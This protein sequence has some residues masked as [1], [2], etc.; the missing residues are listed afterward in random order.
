MLLPSCEAD[1]RQ[2]Q[3]Q[4]VS[5]FPSPSA[6]MLQEG[7]GQPPESL[8][9]SLPHFIDRACLVWDKPFLVS[10]LQF[11]YLENVVIMCESRFLVASDRNPIKSSLSKR[12]FR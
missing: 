2:H 11:P 3:H 5:V 12:G 10:E 8:P 6:S 4:A 1:H 7:P 9:L